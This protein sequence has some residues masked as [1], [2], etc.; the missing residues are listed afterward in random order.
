MRALRVGLLAATAL[1]S[2]GSAHAQRGP[3]WAYLYNP[4]PAE[5]QQWWTNK[6]D[7]TAGTLTNP[8]VV[9]ALALGT[10][11][12]LY[13]SGAPNGTVSAPPGSWYAR[14][15]AAPGA[16]LY[17]KESGA[18]NTGWTAYAAPPAIGTTPGT[19]G[20]GG[21]LAA[22]QATAN[23][24]I[25]SSTLGQPTG[26]AA[27]S[28]LTSEAGTARQNEAAAQAAVTAEAGRAIAAEALKATLTALAAEASTARAAEAAAQA[29]A[30]AAAPQTALTLEQQT[31]RQNEAAALAK[32]VAAVPT[33]TLGQPGGPLV[34]GGTGAVDTNTVLGRSNAARA[35]DVFNPRDYGA[36]G[37]GQAHPSGLTLA[38]LA[39]RY[40][41]ITDSLHGTLFN[42][43]VAANAAV[44]ATT[45]SFAATQTVSTAA[46]VGSTTL[47]LGDVG[48]LSQGMTITLAGVPAGTQVEWVNPSTLQIGLSAATTGAIAANAS[49]SFVQS[50][51]SHVT[52]GM[53][54]SG[55]GVPAGAT[56]TAV[57]STGVTLSAGLT[58]AVVAPTS[59]TAATP[60]YQGTAITFHAPFTDAQAAGLQMDALGIQAA[61]K[62][63]E[64]AG[65]GRVVLPAGVP[66]GKYLVD[67]TI[68]F[69]LP[70]PYGPQVGA[71]LEGDGMA[72]SQLVVP[73]DLGPSRY[74]LS[75]GDPTATAANQR[76]IYAGGG[77]MCFGEWRGFT[78][79]GPGN[80]PF[81]GARPQ[82]NGVPVAMGGA[83]QGPRRNMRYV[84]VTGFNAGIQ[85][86]GDWTTDDYVT[87]G[88]NFVGVRL[89]DGIP[90]LFGD[91][92]YEQVFFGGNSFAG[93]SISPTAGILSSRF[94]KS[95]IADQPYGIWI[96]PGSPP[97]Y[98]PSSIYN[99]VFDD[100]NFEGSGCA[101]IKDGNAKADGS[102]PGG[103]GVQGLKIRASSILPSATYALAAGCPW[104][105]YIDLGYAY[106]LAVTDVD[107]GT[108]PPVAGGVAALTIHSLTNGAT[109]RGGVKLSGNLRNIFDAYA[110]L[111]QEMVSTGASGDF[112]NSRDPLSLEMEIPGVG[113]FR[114][115]F[116][117]PNDAS[118]LA[119]GTLL[120]GA[121]YFGFEMAQRSGTAA[122]NTAPLL[123]AIASPSTA[124]MAGKFV[125]AM[126][127]GQTIPIAVS[128][129][130]SVPGLLQLDTANVG[131]A[132]S[133]A[134]V[135]TGRVIGSVTDPNG[136]SASQVFMQGQF[137]R[138]GP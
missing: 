130:Q 118:A 108:L 16:A 20:D 121:S 1:A 69:A 2:I 5:W 88:G 29:E 78:L 76:G 9:G 42:L 11:Q 4:S 85:F 124:S 26:P 110:A 87:S 36:V 107:E 120:E 98:N 68:V 53:Q 54:A 119:R 49:A 97:P 136:G 28:A 83:K 59:N 14:T 31:A 95:W 103:R 6:V 106:G 94:S 7:A 131:K 138:G 30:N 57:S 13:G 73:A 102:D 84:G 109:G 114:E 134:T 82:L 22:V 19:A 3:N 60:Q 100:I 93:I 105:S 112:F 18:G 127:D 116:L 50:W 43:P 125:T 92:R 39:V 75:C 38:A 71:T 10:V 72:A 44:G 81:L 63:A 45:L 32:A 132:T 33:A 34:Q 122:A 133:A 113:R 90:N 65:G 51:L 55:P 52:P 77:S 128:A 74:A 12:I 86:A 62:A 91:M 56:V 35:G 79:T 27:Q 89:D 64:A 126:V 41:W 137:G 66:G 25:P 104:R 48:G 23:A 70:V 15:D 58:G 117:A 129:A 80:I 99:T 111:G 24:A 135:T 21:V 17:V 61:V 115:Y 37:D 67:Q 101:T 96:E 46:A 123:G 47:L 40:P 8:T